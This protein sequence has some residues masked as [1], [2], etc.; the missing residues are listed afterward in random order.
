M[1]VLSFGSLNFDY[2]YEMDHFVQA[3]ETISSLHYS[4][5]F[6]GKGLNQSIA[7]A[8]AGLE[9]YHAGMVGLDGQA[10][11]DYLQKYGVKTD[12]L[13]KNESLATGHAIIQVCQGENCIILHG[14]A[15]EAIDFKQVD[16][17][18]SHFEKGD[19]LLI[20]NEIS[21]L[22]YLIERAH[23]K[24]LKIAFNVAPMNDK[25]FQYPLSFIDYLIVNEVEA[26]GLGNCDS[27]KIEDIIT[28]L[29]KAYPQTEIVMTVGSRGSY[30]IHGQE[31]VH[32]EAFVVQAK[33]TT[34]AGDTFTGFFLATLFQ[35]ST[36]Q[37]ALQVASKAGS[38][39]VT[40]NGA[41]QSIPSIEEVKN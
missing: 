39:A 38:I 17:V 16:E 11:I 15:N 29:Q 41:A 35:G 8:K 25:V 13:T 36:I 3:K 37:K 26:K 40:R 2:V 18:L 4:R 6:G 22:A 21:S 27:D 7:L 5:N 10:F 28:S 33:D 9:V 31:L 20:Q 19:L 24:G 14:G 23:E 34:A 30:Y 32:Q 1:K 12:Y